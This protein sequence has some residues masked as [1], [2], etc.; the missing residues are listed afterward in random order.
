[1]SEEVKRIELNSP[2]S[3]LMFV[4][5]EKPR[6]INP[7]NPDEQ[8]KYQL[9]LCIDPK[10]QKT[11]QFK[12]MEKAVEKMIAAKWGDNPP[13]KL[14]SPF[15]TTADLEK[16]PDG[17]NEDDVLIRL[18]STAKPEVVDKNVEEILDLSKVYSGCFGIVNMQC[19]PWQHPQGGKG[20]SFGLGPV[21]KVAEGEPL[22][23]RAKPAADAFEALE[24]E[25]DDLEEEDEDDLI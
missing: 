21:Q 1:M 20:V 5:L 25:D 22:G 2:V 13:K 18:S 8:A 3:R 4:N 16:V 14:K 15:L 17:M 6:K 19:Y 23:G 7:N 11:K 24:D 9:S 10:A 12:N